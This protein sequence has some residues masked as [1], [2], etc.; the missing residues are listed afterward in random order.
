MSRDHRKLRVFTLADALV[1]QIYHETHGFPQIERFG[2][3]AQIRRAA[4]SVPCNIVEGCAR[5]TEGEYVNFLN[6]ALGSACETRYLAELA[7]RLGFLE[8]TVGGALTERYGDL[9]RSL[10]ALIDGL[11]CRTAEPSRGGPSRRLPL[12]ARSL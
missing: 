3:Q 8:Q 11:V 6:V 2:L 10:Q 9:V 1:I 7:G 5:R 4:V 12:Q